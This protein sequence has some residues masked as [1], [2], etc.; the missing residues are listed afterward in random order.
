[1]KADIA[2]W[3]QIRRRWSKLTIVCL[4]LDKMTRS[5]G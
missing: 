2:G 1:M 5:S 4:G 3:P